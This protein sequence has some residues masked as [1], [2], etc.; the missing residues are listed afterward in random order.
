MPASL[1]FADVPG[2]ILARAA[3]VRLACFDV[4]GTL[5]NGDLAFDSDGRE[6]KTFHVHDGQGLVLLRKAGIGVALVTARKGGIVERRAADLG[7]EAHVHVADKRARVESLCAA[8]GIGLDEA[9]F[10]GDDLADVG[11]MRA[12]GLA[13][14]P[15]DAHACAGDSAHW[16]TRAG[17]GRGAGRELCDL[18]L[19]AQ[20]RL[21]GI[22][23]DGRIS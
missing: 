23:A 2:A 22:H 3:R 5:T 16:R 20:G 7:V 4:D 6:I 19:H 9:A 12:V 18:I 17:G 15:A 14:A 8:L 1:P 10:M 11:A 21:A 13:V